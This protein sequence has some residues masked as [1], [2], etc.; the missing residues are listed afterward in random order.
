[1]LIQILKQG[2]TKSSE[3]T[4]KIFYF[5]NIYKAL[6][7]AIKLKIWQSKSWHATSHY[8]Q[9]SGQ[10]NDSRGP[11]LKFI[12]GFFKKYKADNFIK[13]LNRFMYFWGD[14]LSNERR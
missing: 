7:R 3:W 4:G 2:L 1:M 8:L 5:R 12:R 10:F 11:H 13:I 6:I 14:V 9:C